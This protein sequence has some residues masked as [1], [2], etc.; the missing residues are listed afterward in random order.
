[1]PLP[2]DKSGDADISSNSVVDAAARYRVLVE[3]LP[4]EHHELFL[5]CCTGEALLDD[6]KALKILKDGKKVRQLGRIQKFVKSCEPMFAALDVFSQVDPIHFGTVWGGVRVLVQLTANFLNFYDRLTE[7][8]FTMAGTIDYFRVVQTYSVASGSKRLAVLLDSVFAEILDFLT[9]VMRIFHTSEGKAKSRARTYAAAAFKPF[10]FDQVVSQ[11]K[12]YRTAVVAELVLLQ[13]IKQEDLLVN[14]SLEEEHDSFRPGVKLFRSLGPEINDALIS[15]IRTWLAPTWY[16]SAYQDACELRAGSTAGWIFEQP[17]YQTWRALQQ[18]SSTLW[19]HG[20]PGSGKTILAAA[21][22]DHEK[23]TSPD[24][25][26]FYFFFDSLQSPASSSKSAY[27]AILSQI[28]QRHSANEKLI[29]MFRFCMCFTTDGQPTAS[30]REAG[31]LLELCLQLPELENS[32]IILDGLDECDDLEKEMIHSLKNIT[33]RASVKSIV[34]GR[35]SVQG[36][37]KNIPGLIDIEVGVFNLDDI[38]EYLRGELTESVGNDILPAKLDIEVTVGRLSRRAD[39]MFLWA[40]L[41]MVYLNSPGLLVSERLEAISDV[42]MPE[43]LERMYERILR[44]MSRAGKTS[45]RLAY[46]VFMCLMYARRPLTMIELED[47]VVSR[48]KGGIDEPSRKIPNFSDNVLSICGGFVE[49]HSLVVERD[50][51]PYPSFRFIHASVKEYFRME[52][53]R[54]I[55]GAAVLKDFVLVPLALTGNSRLAAQ[56]LEYMIYAMPKERITTSTSASTE[57]L[58]QR[59]L[60]QY[61]TINWPHHML[62]TNGNQVAVQEAYTQEPMAYAEFISALCQTLSSPSAISAWIQSCFIFQHEPPVPTLLEWVDDCNRPT[63]PW[64]KHFLQI[65]DVVPEIKSLADYLDRVIREWG[66]H[67]WRDPSCIWEEIGAFMPSAFV[68]NPRGI[69]VRNLVSRKAPLLLSKEPI[70][71]V[72]RLMPN[73]KLDYVLSVFPTKVFVESATSRATAWGNDCFECLEYSHDWLAR[74]EVFSI[75]ECEEVG[76]LEIPLEE[77]EVRLQIFQTLMCSSSGGSLQFPLSMGPDGSHFTILGTLYHIQGELDSLSYNATKIPTKIPQANRNFYEVPPEGPWM[78][79]PRSLFLYWIYFDDSMRYLSLVEQR[80]QNRIL[81]SVFEFTSEKE[82]V[83]YVAKSGVSL[84]KPHDVYYPG[85][86]R[87]EFELAFHPFMPLLAIAGTFDTFIWEFT[88]NRSREGFSKLTSGVTDDHG[89]IEFV[90]FS[91][92]GNSCIT[93]RRGGLPSVVSIESRTA[94]STRLEDGSTSHGSSSNRMLSLRGPSSLTVSPESSVTIRSRSQALS[95][96]GK[97][98]GD[99][100]L[101]N[102][103][104]EVSLSR[105]SGEGQNPESLTLT[106]I[107]NLPG[108]KDIVPGIVLP[109]SSGDPVK[110]VLDKGPTTANQINKPQL[111]TPYPTIVQRHIS[112]IQRSHHARSAGLPNQASFLAIAGP[113]G[114][115]KD[116]VS[117]SSD[118]DRSNEDDASRRSTVDSLSLDI[119]AMTISGENPP[120]PVF[121]TPIFTSSSTT[122]DAGHTG[123]RDAAGTVRVASPMLET[124]KSPQKSKKKHEWSLK[125]LFKRTKKV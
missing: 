65:D 19:I 105:W 70:H 79:D 109:T 75:D 108:S 55:D 97:S 71:K 61:A 112:S 8:L 26:P 69:T 42:D 114:P 49:R 86:D 43:G 54:R 40:R 74:L 84:P 107:P 104:G 67:L 91:S 63:F 123:Y 30:T 103:K 57:L 36:V 68:I 10:R 102:S 89:R 98:A 51:P 4:S 94:G 64:R 52:P 62:A 116:V 56:A 82:R 117:S 44:Q 115:E 39:G 110:I 1:M 83:R 95:V 120:D 100:M 33:L 59:P 78:P 88:S 90:S 15:R 22:V 5:S 14:N 23:A 87:R 9:G 80:P 27:T 18:E 93:K 118:R 53:Q 28:L 50:Q 34:L 24:Q 46:H 11:M 119:P 72:S 6:V 17:A 29:D 12:E 81:V 92:D 66:T 47:S 122:S 60:S 106:R 21:L 77:D 85:R 16:T 124:A 76:S 25:S 101:N 31:D 13:A 35:S 3:T 20:K 7:S 113:D 38:Q 45:L 48:R 96:Q 37:L 111:H 73:G 58:T 125:R 99:V 2:N 41:M 121:L 32:V